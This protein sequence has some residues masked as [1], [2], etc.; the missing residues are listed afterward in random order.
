M[1]S[2]DQKVILSAAMSLDGKIAT[3]TGESAFS[4]KKDKIR[5]HKLRSR[6]DAIIVGKNTVMRDDPLLTVRYAKGKSPTRIIMDSKGTI[7]SNSRII[8]TAQK[9]PTIVVV[10]NRASKKNLT[11]LSRFPIRII[12]MREDRISPTKL[13]KELRKEKIQTILLEG[14]G[15]LNWEFI[16]ENLVDE[17]IITVAPFV[18]GGEEAITLVDGSGFS[19]LSESC[20]L[21]LR[22][23]T[24]QKN[25]V[26][27]YY[28]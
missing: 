15:T 28:N 25:E 9:V 11:R 1:V 13:L 6:V 27:L 18:V 21:R 17:M 16:K 19:K 22:K 10:S 2:Y 14:G 20:K 23:I 7:S 5:F 3:K 24:R 12:K 4:S 26:V 8:K